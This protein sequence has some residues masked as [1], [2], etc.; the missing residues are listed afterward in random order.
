M[1]WKLW[2]DQ[3]DLKRLIQS[4]IDTGAC[5]EFIIDQVDLDEKGK[6]SAQEIRTAIEE[7]RKD[8]LVISPEPNFFLV[9]EWAHTSIQKAIGKGYEASLRFLKKRGVFHRDMVGYGIITQEEVPVER[10][11]S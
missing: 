8:W 4:T 6:Y 11:M 1:K 9:T 7:L 5:L 3:S 2:K 10:K